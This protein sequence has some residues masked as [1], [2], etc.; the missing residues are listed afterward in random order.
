MDDLMLRIGLILLTLLTAAAFAIVAGSME[1]LG[2]EGKSL[3][4]RLEALEDENARQQK[5]LKNLEGIFTDYSSAYTAR[6]GYVRKRLSDVSKMAL[7]I[8]DMKEALDGLQW[9]L[10]ADGESAKAEARAEEAFMTG[11]ANILSYESMKKGGK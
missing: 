4:K 6:V 1:R 8:A 2:K 5:K 11:M 10:E 3:L 9:K 7:D